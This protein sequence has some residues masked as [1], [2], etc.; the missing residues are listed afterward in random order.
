MLVLKLINNSWDESAKNLCFVNTSLQML[1][2]LPEVRS[3]FVN[4]HYK[5]NQDQSANFKICNEVSRIFK[6][7]GHFS[8]SAA[9]LRLLV[10]CESQNEEI[11]NGSQQDITLFIRLLLQEIEK[12][13]TELDGPNALF[14]NKFWGSEH[15]IRKFVNTS[16]GTCSRC[17]KLP[18]SENE[19]FNM[20]KLESLNT[21]QSISLSTMIQ[22]SFLEGAEIFKMKCSEC[23]PHQGGCPLT[24][25]CQ[26]KN[27]VDHR[28][29]NRTPDFLFI[30]LLRFSNFSNLKTK[31]HV[32][33]EEILTLPNGETFK[34]V[35][36][37]DHLGDLIRNG[38]YV[39]AVKTEHGWII[40]DDEKQYNVREPVSSNNYIF[41]Y[42]KILP[43]NLNENTIQQ[44]G[45]QKKIVNHCPNCKQH[46]DNLQQHLDNSLICYQVSKL[47]KC[48]IMLPR[49]IKT[50]KVEKKTT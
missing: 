7:A 24:G 2:S 15:V 38:H 33:P 41:L 14:I 11:C 26:P 23:C 8:I 20:L 32:A 46:V 6:S 13:L 17:G 25:N 35:S 40:C 19:D 49:I 45:K 1:Y 48:H 22:N 12:E 27:A 21:N 34:L 9:T 50:R 18:R 36:I 47:K 31:T 30:H 44:N 29:L 37:A 16:D 10:G 5:V 4:Q 3:F 39:S 42:C 28:L 43:D